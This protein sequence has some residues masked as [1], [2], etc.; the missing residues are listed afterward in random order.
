MD[1]S[2]GICGQES[3]ASTRS[4]PS[5][6]ESQRTV[7]K[8]YEAEKRHR[9]ARVLCYKCPLFDACERALSDMERAGISVDGVMA[10]R[11]SDIPLADGY[12][13][14]F[15]SECIACGAGL[16]PQH[17][18]PRKKFPKSAKRHVGEG[19]CEEC[20]PLLSRLNNTMKKAS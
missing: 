18:R 13:S 5:P 9:R 3:Y 11:Y 4:L 7:E 2:M 1:E 17:R 6:W 16:I 19:L 12:T 10:G 8:Q 14:T 15:Q 20:Y